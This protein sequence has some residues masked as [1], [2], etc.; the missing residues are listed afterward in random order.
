MI[1]TELYQA[2]TLYPFQEKTVQSILQ[3]LS[4]NG[5]EFNNSSLNKSALERLSQI[6]GGHYFSTSSNQSRQ[7][8]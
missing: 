5:K 6:S 2:K 3:E 1:D 4:D 7:N 8:E